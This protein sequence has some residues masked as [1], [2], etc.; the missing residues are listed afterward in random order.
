MSPHK[1]IPRD[2]FTTLLL[3]SAGILIAL[4]WLALG[5]A[6]WHKDTQGAAAAREKAATI[7]RAMDER[8]A[9][10][11]RV[12]DQLLIWV[13]EEIKE[14]HAWS[15]T[16]AVTTVL[17]RFTPQ[18]DEILSVAFV[19]ALGQSVSQSNPTVPVGYSYAEDDCFRAHMKA[20]DLG[21]L[22]GKPVVG[23]ASG[24]RLFT[25][26]RRIS[27]SGGE[28]LGVL[29]AA[30]RT[31]VLAA[32]FADATIGKHGAANLF[33]IPS[34]TL[35]VRQPDYLGTFAKTL[36]YPDLQE[37]LAGAPTGVFRGNAS[38]DGEERIFAFRR[39]ADL[40]LAV[41]VGLSV[42]D[43]R[44]SFSREFASYLAMALL[45]SSI[46]AGG[47]IH[48]LAAYR[49]EVDLQE[50][51][52]RWQQI[53]EHAGWGIVIGSADGKTLEQMNPAYAR[54]HGYSVEELTGQPIETVYAPEV[55]K[56]I[57]AN[58]ELNH[59]QGH[60]HFESL[61][62]HRDGHVFPV[63]ADATT[64]RG[65]S[66]EVLYR[67]VNVQDI[68][69]IRRVQEEMRIAKEFF[70]H[71]FED[72]A[73]SMAIANIDGRYTK[74]NRAMCEF[75]GY[76]ASELLALNYVDITHPD[77]VEESVRAR[78]SL[79]DCQCKSYQMEK[80]YIRKDGREIWAL[81]AASQVTDSEGRPLYSIV[82]MLDIDGQKQAERALRISE[83]RFRGI[84]ENANTGIAATD[85]S[86][87]VIYFNEAFRAMLGHE[88]AALKQMNFADFTFPEDLAR[89]KELIAEVLSRQRE[90]YRLEKRYI[91]RDGRILWV[92]LY[93]STIRD[94]DGGIVNFIGVAS[95]ITERKESALALADSRQ[96]LRDL[97]AYQEEMLERERKHIARE[98]H[99]ELGQL[100]TAL[101]MD[102]SLMRLRFGEN[103]ALRGMLEE[104]RSLIERTINVTRQVASN[105]RPAALDLGL[106]PAIEW[107]ADDFARRWSVPC[108][109]DASD[110]EITLSELQ[111]TTVFRVIQESM[112]NVA[113]HAR[114]REV[115][116]SL[117]ASEH[118]L[119]VVVRDD[120]LGFDPV[121][122]GKSRGFGLF[123]MRERVLA[124]GGALRIDS[125]PGE[126]TA[127]VI[128]LPLLDNEHS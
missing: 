120:G 126:G 44:E 78:Q 69:E 88:T 100:L 4:A 123:G 39:I 29:V 102:L 60:R 77:D 74:V 84:F 19:N 94:E 53:F 90:Q 75:T 97:A 98:V 104:M 71:T 59:R 76:S 36:P 124:L 49:R 5:L 50:S 92:D 115:T 108:R 73:V 61:H 7:A 43:I 55:R 11:L 72:A 54:M 56:D 113:R 86:G 106:I 32:D 58:I 122:V 114:A 31:D 107:L 87:R 3:A 127:V 30:I 79:L 81:M 45:L 37:A 13:G 41:S 1:P 42:G 38:L 99:D 51:M 15:D 62:L 47:A 33:H 16:H 20:S 9:R 25:I 24:Q 67:V 80:R 52:H 105:L 103:T 110:D 23:K 8:V 66:G 26:S 83:E 121:A 101:K 112:T 27:G 89:E 85:K 70:Q 119:Q 10:T 12:A 96:Q 35:I 28:F 48:I 63:R 17:R 14:K 111:S 34:R 68:S 125:A 40:P 82:Q 118:Q 109:I 18:L 93:V 57:P 65:K 64:I 22:V 116:I 91:S 46:I 117:H 6:L 128:E 2:S 21:L 95:D